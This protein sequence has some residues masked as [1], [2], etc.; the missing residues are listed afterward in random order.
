MELA[1][2][3]RAVELVHAGARNPR[4]HPGA[5]PAMHSEIFAASSDAHATAIAA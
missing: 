3:P 5:A 2:L 4:W 1:S